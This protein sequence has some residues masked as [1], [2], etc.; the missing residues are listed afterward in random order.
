MNCP[1]CKS[2]P[3]VEAWAV[4]YAKYRV[5]CHYCEQMKTEW[6]E[7]AEKAWEEWQQLCE[8]PNK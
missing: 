4:R 1:I 5:F 2:E 7:T 3:D 6:H 8:E